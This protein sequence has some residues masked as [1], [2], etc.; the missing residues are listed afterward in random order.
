MSAENVFTLAQF[1]AMLMND[2]VLMESVTLL[3]KEF[4]T[5]DMGLSIL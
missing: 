1:T 5:T 4:L 3:V 2:R